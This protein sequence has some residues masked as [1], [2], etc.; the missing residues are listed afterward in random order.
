M[1]KHILL[2][3]GL[4]LILTAAA[5]TEPRPWSIGFKWAM[6]KP[7]PLCKNNFVGCIVPL[8]WKC[9]YESQNGA[10]KVPAGFNCITC[11]FSPMEASHS[12]QT[13]NLL[14]RNLS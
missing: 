6:K 9:N 13:Q 10:L 7:P 8:V 1:K 3:V 5:Q 4:A 11:M 2:S 14:D 12:V